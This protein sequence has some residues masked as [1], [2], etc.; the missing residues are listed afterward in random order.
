VFLTDTVVSNGSVDTGSV[1]MTFII[2][3]NTFIDWTD[4]GVVVSGKPSFPFCSVHW[5]TYLEDVFEECLHTIEEYLCTVDVVEVDERAW[6][7]TGLNR[8]FGSVS[9]IVRNV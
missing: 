2:T 5:V 9:I 8:T 7:C 1:R 4:E 3:G 6:H